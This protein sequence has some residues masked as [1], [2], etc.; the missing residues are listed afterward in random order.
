M[1]GACGANIGTLRV[2]Y[3]IPPS[4]FCNLQADFP[5]LIAENSYEPPVSDTDL[6]SKQITLHRV[7]LRLVPF[8]FVY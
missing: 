1:G 7:R 4:E 3:K 6:R 2:N 5:E 8:E